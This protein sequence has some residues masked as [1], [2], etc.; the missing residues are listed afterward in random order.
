MRGRRWLAAAGMAMVMAVLGAQPAQ[1]QLQHPR[2]EW[3]RN[4]T[5]GLFLHWGMFTAPRHYDCQE[6]EQAVTGG[7]W[8]PDYWIEEAQKLHASYVV[9]TTF[10]SRLG[11]AR[12][13]P[14]RIPGSCAT[15]RDFLGELIAA[16][17]REGVKVL[18]YMTD[19]PQWHDEQGIETLDSEAYSA[20]KGKEVDLTTR[21]GFGEYSYDLF[22]EV[23]ESYPGLAGFWIDN[24]NAYWERNDL[25]EQ[26][27]ERRPSWLLS[28]NNE[29]TPIMDTVSNEQKTGMDPYYA[30]P[31]A[32]FT[33]MPRLTEA[34]YKLPTTGAW[35]YDGRDH[36]VDFRLSVGRYITNAG[37][38]IK[39]LMAETA[40]VNGRF[41]PQQEAFNDFMAEYLPPIWES[42][43]GTE[44]G[45]Y[46][47][48]GMQPGRWN[49]GSY[50]VITVEK[51]NDRRQ[52]VHV[53]TRPTSDDFVRI[54]DN[55]YRVTRVTEVRTGEEMVFD[56]SGGHLTI[57]GIEDWDEYDTVFEVR[58]AGRQL[59]HDQ[60]TIE[61]T[62]S[63]ET[64]SGP[65]SNLADGS[66]LGYW[67]ADRTVPST[68]E[69]DLGD[70][71]P[72]A[73]LAINQ[74]EWS[75]T[76]D[77][78]TFGRPETSSRIR[79]YRVSVSDDG[80]S[81]EVVRTGALPSARGVQFI[82]LGEQLT[83]HIRLEI[84]STWGSP[85]APNEFEKVAIDELFV[86]RRYVEGLGDGLAYEAEARENTLAGGARRARCGAC[87]GGARV[88]LG[89]GSL[90]YTDVQVPEDGDRRLAI[91]YTGSGS[92]GVSVNGAPAIDVPAAAQST[93]VPERTAIAVPLRAG[94]NRIEFTGDGS[95]GL[96]RIAVS[97]I[98]DEPPATSLTVDPEAVVVRPGTS[99]EVSGTFRLDGIDPISNVSLAPRVPDGWTVEGAPATAA[100]M[101]PGDT[102]AGS[103]TITRPADGSY[104][105]VDVPIVAA[106]EAF[107]RP[108][109]AQADVAVEGLPPGWLFVAEGEAP[110][111]TFSGNVGPGRCNACSGGEKLRFIGNSPNNYV[112]FEDVV[113][114]E[115]GE[116]TLLIDYT[117]NGTRSFFVTVN[118]DPPIEVPITGTSWDDPATA[119]TTVTLREGV[120]TI[121]IHNDEAYAPDLDRIRISLPDDGS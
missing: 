51:G 41:P 104:E 94:A 92:F 106:F 55:G 53:T 73:Y 33:P 26:I 63:A 77:R 30:Y 52:F 37:S 60:E 83:R 25:Y 115:A 78:E 87:S 61:A 9:L 48:G 121:K 118:D 93:D 72:A 97:A 99:F 109:E 98:P 64:G 67:D 79:D 57:L 31:E 16:G 100:W 110:T 103:W 13:W 10:H 62:A 19:D 40:M 70:R 116:Y 68:I 27:R 81:W 32:V 74:R 49:D 47:Y 2:Q 76:Y 45:G 84:L 107:G 85:H 12:P 95:V 120:N 39:S 5:A 29:D 102:L 36:D 38:S 44:G 3:L 54:R 23:M 65:A 90:A 7:G 50:G 1:A 114:D 88:D 69:L 28:N 46:M 59:F 22:F 17:E 24:D 108:H 113:A 43:H 71:K 6:W 56:Q 101:D 96:D 20:Y 18:L 105:T 86:A 75:P 14:S 21:D 8:T 111:N 89:D 112:A 117:V 66:F 34:D 11:Y 4:S 80:E 119:S 82:D 58:T 42:I 91:H 35:W 15:E